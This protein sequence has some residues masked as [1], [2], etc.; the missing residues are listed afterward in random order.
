MN[1]MFRGR[2]TTIIAAASLVLCAASAWLWARSYRAGDFL[3]DS[4]VDPAARRWW[5]REFWSQ[6][7]IIRVGVLRVD[8]SRCAAEDDLTGWPDGRAYERLDGGADEAWQPWLA[9]DAA[10]TKRSRWDALPGQEP[11]AGFRVGKF[12]YFRAAYKQ[13]W[14]QFER[15]WF[16][17]IPTWV[18]VVLFAIPPT[19]ELRAMLR[20]R[21]RHKRGLCVACG[22]DVR[23]SGERCPECGAIV[24]QQPPPAFANAVGDVK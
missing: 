10:A 5:Q 24:V 8:K 6:A 1:R 22:Y 2:G 11:P 15:Y 7:G 18:F 13:S 21:S 4:V 17:A 20:R 14:G 16:L 3:R 19:I 23:A 12:G 9:L